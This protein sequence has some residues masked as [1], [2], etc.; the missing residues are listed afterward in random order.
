MSLKNKIQADIKEALKEGQKEKLEA[1]R[2]FQSKIKNAEIEKKTDK[3]ETAALNAL[4]KTHLKQYDEAVRDYVQ[5]GKSEQAEKELL[6]MEYLKAY[7]PPPID[8]KEL[9]SIISE[10]IVSKK[11]KG[12]EDQG[13]IIKEVQQQTQ[14]RADNVKIV[15]LVRQQ[16][17]Q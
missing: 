1:L 2:L 12:L 16:L 13:L 14:G 8:D 3:L 6:K 7:L 10:I 4:L 5:A 9:S 11:P 15:H 17:K